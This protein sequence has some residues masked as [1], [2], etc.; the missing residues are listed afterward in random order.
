MA[1]E[2]RETASKGKGLFA[3]APIP[4]GH[5]I[6]EEEALFIAP[7]EP[8]FFDPSM[9]H[10]KYMQLPREQKQ[11]VYLTLHAS[12][13]I[14]TTIRNS[15]TTSLPD[16]ARQQMANVTSIFET[17]AFNLEGGGGSEEKPIP[18]TGLFP[19]CA[20]LNHSCT[21]NAAQTWNAARQRLTIHATKDIQPEEEICISY[22]A[23]LYLPM[24]D[25]QTMLQGH[26]FT[27]DCSACDESASSYPASSERRARILRLRYDINFLNSR[28]SQNYG[29]SEEGPPSSSV[30][31]EAGE[32]DPRPAVREACELLKEEGLMGHELLYWYDYLVKLGRKVAPG[33]RGRVLGAA[34]EAVG[35]SLRTKGEDHP[36]TMELVALVAELE[37]KS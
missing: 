10:T 7:R 3:T 6:I 24:E 18:D 15:L 35:W 32:V 11:D 8:G 2:V 23:H 29:D 5:R 28:I 22:L 1:H 34:R 14:E 36:E 30:I 33:D 26:D 12:K 31:N 20:R 17:N 25:R 4:A 27:C 13:S 9:I 19:T 16:D 21:P 37:G